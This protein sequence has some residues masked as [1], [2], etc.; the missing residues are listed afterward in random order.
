MTL[1]ELPPIKVDIERARAFVLAHGNARER[2]RLDGLFGVV[3]PARDVVKEL[4]GLQNTDGGFPARGQA[5][6]PSSI[7][8]TCYVL[9]Q[10]KE[11]PPLAGAPMASRALAYL[12]RTQ[13]PDGFWQESAEAAPLVGPW[14]RPDNPGAALYLT[15]VAAFSVLTLEPEHM[16]PLRRAASWSRQELARDGVEISTQTLVLAW[17][18]LCRLMGPES[19]E[20]RWCFQQ[21]AQR[22]MAAY[23]AA[24]FLLCGLEVGAG[25]SYV[26]PIAQRLAQLAGMQQEDGSWPAEPGFALESTLTALRVFRGYGVL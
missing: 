12:R 18:A 9:H 16:D 26:L 21:A 4:E 13:R 24:W 8:A 19:Q 23:E 20:A 1:V 2:A 3:G 11:M 6:A 17:G 7:D 5:G 25:G 10:L 15:A 22:S 14:A